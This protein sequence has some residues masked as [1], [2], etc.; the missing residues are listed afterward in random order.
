MAE[1]SYN[2]IRT[3]IKDFL[4]TNLSWIT[5]DTCFDYTP[6]APKVV[7]DKLPAVI[8]D[9]DR[10]YNIEW[11]A[12]DQGYLRQITFLIEVYTEVLEADTTGRNASQDI[13]TKLRELE[14]LFRSDPYIKGLVK[15]LTVRATKCDPIPIDVTRLT[16]V[17]ARFAWLSVAVKAFA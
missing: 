3:G 10:G 7:F 14:T 5:T 9:F 6:L 12:V 15:G 1:T 11:N 17:K 16:G 13:A 8:V 4:V 2:A